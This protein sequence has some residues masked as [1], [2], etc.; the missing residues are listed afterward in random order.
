VQ[1]EINPDSEQDSENETRS[2][3]PVAGNGSRLGDSSRNGL[4][5]AGAAGAG[6]GVLGAGGS[7]LS[8]VGT[9][10]RNAAEAESLTDDDPPAFDDDEGYG[11][12]DENFD[13]INT[14]GGVTDMYAPRSRYDDPPAWSFD[15]LKSSNRI[16]DDSDD[17]ASD[18]PNLGSDGRENL[19][20]RLMEDF[21]DDLDGHAGESTPVEGIPPR[22]GGEEG[23]GEVTEIR[24]ANN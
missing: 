21:G 12:Y 18:A 20:S 7:A 8:G 11:D 22:L 16:G 19:E 15:N 1:G 13:D 4:S 3:S 14:G 6:V 24:I 23:D 2:R 17:V 5:R 10:H 9:H